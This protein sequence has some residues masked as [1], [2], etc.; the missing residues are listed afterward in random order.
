MG[1]HHH[2][3]GH[4]HHG[5]GHHHHAGRN[6]GIAFLLNFSFAIIEFVGGLWTGS[7]AI[8]SDAVHDFG[9]SLS[10]GF[11]LVMEKLSRRKSTSSF[12]YGFQRFS[13]L[14]AVINA[15]VLVAGSIYVLVEA[16]PRL[17]N[18][19]HPTVPGMIG[20]AILG[21]TVNGYAAWKVSH[22]GTMSERV[23]TW[24]LME[25]VLGW[26]V[27]LIGSCVMYF[28][29]APII[30]PIL[31]IGFT[32]FILWNVVKS[33]R[34]TLKLFLQAAPEQVD[35]AATQKGLLQIPGVK[36]IHDFHIWSL[37]GQSHVA[38][39]H[40][41]ISDTSTLNDFQRIKQEIHVNLQKLGNIHVTV[42]LDKE[43]EECSKRDCVT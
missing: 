13:L 27:I 7:I 40:A 17:T 8:Q 32:L 10:L 22:G 2:H 26:V 6:L 12:S 20:L 36:G 16:I 34:S 24:H 15:A 28:I 37:D 25:D 31:S 23:I 9:D 3:H 35:L 18:P 14:A 42:E 5:H 38:T 30:D 39:L 41:V 33:L 43:S 29:D 1:E 4:A 19:V 11:A 21:V